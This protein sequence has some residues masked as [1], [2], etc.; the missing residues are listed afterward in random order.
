LTQS[1]KLSNQTIM[2]PVKS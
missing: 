2:F 1:G